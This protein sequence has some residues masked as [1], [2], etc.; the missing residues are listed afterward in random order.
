MIKLLDHKNKSIAD[1]I[2]GIQIPAYRKEADIIHYH[3]IPELHETVSSIVSSKETFIGCYREDHLAGVLSY[4]LDIDVIRICRLVVH[5]DYFRKGIGRELLE[6]LV[7][8][9]KRK[10]I[11]VST[12]AE[13][14]P[15]VEMYKRFDFQA[16][17]RSEPVK[18]VFLI[19][20]KRGPAVRN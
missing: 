9:N 10:Q 18:G 13:N 16:V 1:S 3:D 6:D 12:G 5:P 4:E 11:E 2:L 14:H 20:L 17:S 19:H 15:A 8:Q 7:L